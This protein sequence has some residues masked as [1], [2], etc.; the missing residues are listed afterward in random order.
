MRS[1]VGCSFLTL[2]LFAFV[3][4]LAPVVASSN[5]PFES[6]VEFPHPLERKLSFGT[7]TDTHTTLNYSSRA[8]TRNS[9]SGLV[10]G[11]LSYSSTQRSGKSF[12]HFSATSNE[13]G[14]HEM[15][16]G[17][18]GRLKVS[19]LHGDGSG[20]S[21]YRK[22][23][24]GINSNYFHGA[25]SRP[26]R[27]NGASL[28]WSWSKDLVSHAGTVSINAPD[29]DTR[30]VHYAGASLGGA[31]ATY[32][33]FERDYNV[34]RGL[35]LGW[36]GGSFSAGIEAIESERR[37]SWREISIAYHD[38]V[39][40]TLR[41]SYSSGSNNLYAEAAGSRVGLSY[42]F[43]FGAGKRT[44]GATREFALGPEAIAARE[45]SEFNDL[46]H[47][48]LGAVGFGTVVSSGNSTLDQSPRFATQP[49]AAYA[50][51]SAIN[52][53]SVSRNREHGG[54]IFRNP[55]G[56]YSPSE[57][58]IEG[59]PHSV[60][61]NPHD[62][63]PPGTRATADWHTHGAFDPNYVNE[64]FSP[65][66]IAFSHHYGIDG[67]LGTPQGRMFEYV[68]QEQQIYQYLGPDGNEFILPH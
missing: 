19:L 40:G 4:T 59:T 22:G 6:D 66:D 30:S 37:A 43:S 48:G 56:T 57:S 27:Y 5:S 47:F 49:Q 23:F 7:G 10:S 15:L 17:S 11:G 63:V 25:S 28:A 2:H 9:L 50:I 1:G 58:V 20:L 65:Q 24:N 45:S 31:S 8:A 53:I 18:M 3:L 62:L 16:G 36:R 61:Y 46:T 64:F 68:L 51:L 54:S 34:S 12:L 44:T 38:D 55:D 32:Y 29:V 26:Y 21:Q 41:L 67:Y 60:A 52:P 14:T 35:T 39:G 13:N 42:G 33:Q